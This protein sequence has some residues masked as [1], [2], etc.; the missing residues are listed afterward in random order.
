MASVQRHIYTVNQ[1]LRTRAMN[2]RREISKHEIQFCKR[3]H[4]HL[5]QLYF[6][7]VTI[8]SETISV[9][10]LSFSVALF[11]FMLPILSNSKSMI[12]LLF[13]WNEFTCCISSNKH[14]LSNNGAPWTWLTQRLHIYLD[15]VL[16]HMAHRFVQ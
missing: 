13:S 5:S 16:S 12:A 11:L 6:S 10:Q 15:K 8:S 2:Q 7:F 3:E 14:A 1:N 4:S 9:F